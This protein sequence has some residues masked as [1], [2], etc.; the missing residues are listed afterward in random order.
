[1][2]KL[3]NGKEEAN[4]DAEKWPLHKHFALKKEERNA[5]SLC[6]GWSSVLILEQNMGE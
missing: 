1:M 5:H 6:M 4:V 3:T 2:E